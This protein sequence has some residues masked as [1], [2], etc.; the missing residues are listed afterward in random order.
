MAKISGGCWSSQGIIKSGDIRPE[1]YVG[2]LG[3]LAK[4]IYW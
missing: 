4:K 2:R 1:C 3:R